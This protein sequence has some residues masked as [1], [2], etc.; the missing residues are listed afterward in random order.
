M[1]Q[2]PGTWRLGEAL[3]LVVMRFWGKAR[4]IFFCGLTTLVFWQNPAYSA[5]DYLSELDAEV[6]KVDTRSI[7]DE[8]AQARRVE[9]PVK[10][11]KDRLSASRDRFEALLKKKYLG[12]F[13][14]YKKLPE[15]TREEIFLEYNMGAPITA[16]RKKIIDRLLQR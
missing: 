14:F 16:V 2:I 13:G 15:R 11:E 12:T 8:G 7:G 9:I 6:Q 10:P 4:G 5:D 1:Q 3:Y